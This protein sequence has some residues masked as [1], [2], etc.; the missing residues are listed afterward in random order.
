M[1]NDLVDGR[2]FDW[3][4]R[5]DSRNQKFRLR[6]IE[7]S[8]FRSDIRPRNKNWTQRIFLDQG[9]EGACT[10]FG[11]AHMLGTTPR[12]R[13]VDDATARELYYEARR[14]DEYD[15][16]AYEGSSVLGVMQA[17]KLRGWIK[18]YLWIYSLDELI[19]AISFFGPVVAG[20]PVYEGM[21]EPDANGFVNATGQLLG[22][23][24]A[25]WSGVQIF[26]QWVKY[27]NSWGLD[28]GNRGSAKIAF[29]TVEFLFEKGVEIALPR[30]PIAIPPKNIL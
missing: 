17:L 13:K 22:G 7:A 29:P 30:K 10:G 12:V 27:N 8:H 15:G 28:W 14:N 5:D 1:V 25:E 21:M 18:D 26:D 2:V 9:R 4:Q 19:H 6:T 3:R 11:G 23:H 20:F 16:E 24:C